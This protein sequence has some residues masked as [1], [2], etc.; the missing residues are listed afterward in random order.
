MQF[1]ILEGKRELL[2]KYG[3]SLSPEEFSRIYNQIPIKLKGYGN[4]F[5]QNIL[6]GAE[7][8]KLISTLN[9]FL[10]Y[11]DR[12]EDKD[13][14][15]YSS[16]AEVEVA[17]QG[18]IKKGSK[19]EKLYNAE[20]VYEDDEIKVIVPLTHEASR[21]YGTGTNWCTATASPKHFNEY[22]KKGKLFYILPKDGSE[23]YA[24]FAY[25]KST[26]KEYFDSKDKPVNP[27]FIFKK[28]NLKKD[29]FVA[30]LKFN[31]KTKEGIKEFLDF[32]NIK[33]YKI[34]KDLSVDVEGD[35]SIA[36]L[37]LPQI[38]IEF[39][40]V[41]GDFYCG[42]NSL[43]S[44]QGAPQEVGGGFYCEYN[45]LTSLQGAPQKVDGYFYCGNNP[46]LPQSEIDK[47]KKIYNQVVESVVKFRIIS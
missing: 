38:P 30:K 24:V 47:L 36:N 33:N 26:T 14:N 31:Y 7:M 8:P 35:V 15:H 5:F 12:L 23:K 34:N 2:I 29:L 39:V 10:K 41:G 22:K 45:S 46:K 37:N 13:I 28:F 43:T 19:K 4:W 42:S 25:F 27:L 17:V 21:H 9:T 32:I 6:K 44:L 40:K 11:K 1:K 16:E 3:K 18:A 20:L